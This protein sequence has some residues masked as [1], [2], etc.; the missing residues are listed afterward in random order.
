MYAVIE[1]G[2]KQYRVSEGDVV[3]VER[4]PSSL[5]DEVSISEVHLVADGDNVQVG[6]PTVDGASVVGT[7]VEEGRGKKV[8]AFKKKRRKGYQ[9]KIGHRQAYTALRID[10]IEFS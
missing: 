5:G 9:R 10:K 8:I 7:V 2:G 4:L 6:T 3:R 1:T